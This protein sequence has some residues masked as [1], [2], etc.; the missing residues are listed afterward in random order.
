VLNLGMMA[1]ERQVKGFVSLSMILVNAFQV[2]V[3]VIARC[4]ADSALD[5]RFVLPPTN[6]GGGTLSVVVRFVIIRCSAPW[7]RTTRAATRH[8]CVSSTRISRLQRRPHARAR[9]NAQGLYIWD[10][11]Y[12]EA[13]VLTTMDVTTDGFG[14]M[15]CF[16]S[17]L[18][19]SPSRPP[20][21]PAP[22]QTALPCSTRSGRLAAG[23]FI[24][25]I[26]PPGR[27]R[28]P[29]VGPLHLFAAR[30]LS[31]HTRPAGLLSDILL[32]PG[33]R[34]EEERELGGG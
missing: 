9:R 28:R 29:R 27:D 17:P 10:A 18:L 34:E 32:V 14:F 1:K 26:P 2:C 13:A 3:W 15:L 33:S 23:L 19:P 12:H 7:S 24:P 20:P 30:A 25:L 22:L 5:F 31:R 8:A 21:C 16:G 4:Q 11:L 6:L